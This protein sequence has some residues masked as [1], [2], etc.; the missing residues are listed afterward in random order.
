MGSLA[1]AAGPLGLILAGPLADT[2][3]LQATFFA[4]SAPMLLVAAI[5]FVMPSLRE[6]DR[7]PG[8]LGSSL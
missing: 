2:A 3:G 1:Y 8:P 5:A 7:D 6:L 4:L